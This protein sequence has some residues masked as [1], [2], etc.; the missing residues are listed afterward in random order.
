MALVVFELE[1]YLLIMLCMDGISLPLGLTDVWSTFI[2]ILEDLRRK[3]GYGTAT[4]LPC[5][6]TGLGPQAWSQLQKPDGP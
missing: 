5:A 3:S 6:K 4:Q 1:T 2:R